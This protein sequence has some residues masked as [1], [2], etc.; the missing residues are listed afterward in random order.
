[1]EIGGPNAFL[2][3]FAPFPQSCSSATAF[4]A[5]SAVAFWLATSA[6]FSMYQLVGT[7]M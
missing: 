2:F 6:F 1:M 5:F 7:S 4:F 3:D